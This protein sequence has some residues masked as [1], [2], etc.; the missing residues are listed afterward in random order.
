MSGFLYFLADHVGEITDEIL[1]RFGV[2]YAIE[3]HEM[4][5]PRS[6]VMG[7]GGRSGVLIAH[8]SFPL[9]RLVYVSGEQEWLQNPKLENTWVG[10][11]ESDRIGPSDLQRPALVEG[12]SVTLEDGSKWRAAYARRFE[13]LDGGHLRCFCPLPKTLTA[14]K[15]GWAPTR[16]A[17][18]YRRLASLAELFWREKLDAAKKTESETF[19]WLSKYADELAVASLTANYRIAETELTLLELYGTNSRSELLSVAMD[20]GTLQEWQKK[21]AETGQDGTLFFDGPMP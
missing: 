8:K 1:V 6:I 4:A 15:D 2:H 20:D 7:P 12:A 18:R 14:T 5:G 3:R 16:I 11:W 9:N 21:T 13:F 10:K 17:K 19:T